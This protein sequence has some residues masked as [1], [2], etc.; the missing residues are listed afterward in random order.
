MKST[1]LMGAALATVATIN[2][3]TVAHA[4][5]AAATSSEEITVTGSRVI[6]NGNGSPTPLTVVTPDQL[7]T[8]KP[9]TVYQNLV[10]LPAFAGSRGASNGPVT[11]SPNAAGGNQPNGAV[12]SLNLRNMGA[13]RNLVLFDGHRVP[14]ASVDGLV[15]VSILPQMLIQRVD[16]VTGGASAVYG[17]DAITGVTNFIVDS[18][19]TGLKA[20]MQGG[21]SQHNDAGSY[22]VGIAAGSNV[23]SDRGH[24]EFS[25][26]H[27][28]DNGLYD[29]QRD[30]TAPRW[31]VQG[32]GTTIPWHLVANVSNATASFGGS[33]ACPNGNVTGCAGTLIGYTFHQNGVA[34]PYDPGQT[35]AAAGLFLSTVQIGG[36]GAYFRNVA[37]KSASRQDQYFG[38]F[39]Y[40]L[41]D[42]LHFYVTGAGNVNNVRG[43]TGTQ[44]SFTP[45]WNI[46]ACNAF[47]ATT[48]QSQFGCTSGNSGTATEPTFRFEK[49]F[50][51]SDNYG[52][53]QNNQIV[54]HNYF[55]MA[56]LAGKLGDNFD[57]DTTYTHSEAKIEVAGLNQNR[58]HIYAALDAVVNPANGQIVCRTALT[59]PGLNAGCVPLNPF[60]PTAASREA[61]EYLFDTIH[62]TAANKLD[63]VS[64]S[65]TGAPFSLWAGPID[66]ALS[67]EYRRLR[68]DLD[69]DSLASQLLDC[70]GLRFG[71]CSPT[72]PV[73][74]NTWLPEHDVTQG[75]KEVA[76]EINVPLLKDATL[77]KSLAFNGAARY[78]KYDNKPGDSGFTEKSFEATTWK[79]GIVW[80]LA[81]ML[82]VRATRSRDIRAPSLYDLYQP[83]T[84]G[85]TTNGFDYLLSPNGVAISP[86]LKSGGNPDLQ[87][88]IGNTTTVGLVL[89][90]FSG[91]SVALDYYDI[92]V[93]DALYSLNGSTQVIQQACY[94]SGGASPL[95]QLQERP[96]G[97]TNTTAANAMTAFY[98]RQ[99]NIAEQKTSG[100]DLEANWR[101]TIGEM[102]FQLR[103][104]FTYQPHIYYYI[105]FAARQDVAGVA[106][107]Q[108]GGLPTPKFRGTVFAH[109]NLTDRF[110]IDVQERWRS[111]LHF[112]SDPTQ[113]AEEGETK[114]VA[115]TNLTLTYD[116]PIVG[117]ETSW[118]FNVQNVF[119]KDPPP[120]GALN[121]TFPGSFPGTYAVGDDVVGRYFTLGVRMRY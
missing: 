107:P 120:A 94:A 37:L 28:D 96:L 62:S 31:S 70:T 95:C 39:D 32:N 48:Y 98:T 17:S 89:R 88:E 21:V 44:R 114:A 76:Y 84:V 64:G 47:L 78:T 5:T 106:Y 73:H 25:Y 59:N 50:L 30:W 66:M 35:G 49:Q 53:G 103:G 41:T 93:T 60:G 2:L 85:N 69:T 104:I 79:A 23:F 90:P 65:I 51:P 83:I 40:D 105:P 119:D 68:M 22:Q 101:T 36:D 92:D 9:T 8:T 6:T 7:L 75:V 1:L 18:K 86:R 16:V 82:T 99:V 113:A 91:M 58:Q 77:F 12:S 112:S 4:Q 3:G 54:T 74:P 63:G 71:N 72:V 118:F 19:F 38:R 56:D 13:L 11:T 45:G 24:I 33:V 26:Q 46:G 57:W 67:G 61:V 108:I 97:F 20:V 80:D 52:I 14:P 111:A 110:A 102:P 34:T 55:I 29:T 87:P 10:D 43:N 100:Y 42:N 121:A 116:L 117:H 15:D 115:Y 27:L 81:D 109:L